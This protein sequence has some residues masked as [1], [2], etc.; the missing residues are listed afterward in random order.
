MKIAI[1]TELYLPSIGGQQVRYAEL[2]K[3]LAARGHSVDVFTIAHQPGLAA[4]ETVDGVRI[5]RLVSAPRYQ[6]KGGFLSRDVGAIARFTLALLARLRTL[7]GYDLVLFNQWPVLPQIVCGRLLGRRAAV[8]WC[9]IRSSRFW[10]VLNRLMALSCARHLCVSEAIGQVLVEKFGRRRDSVAAVLSGIES[11][12][13]AATTAE[14]EDGLILFLGR[15]SE[16]KNPALLVE[17][18]IADPELSSRCHLVLAGDGEQFDTLR[19]RTDGLPSVTL[20][21]L[22]SDAEKIALLRKA[23]LLVLPSRREGFPRVIAEAAAAGTPVVTVDFPDNGSVH[24]V[25]KYGLGWVCAPDAATLG[26]T[27]R[28]RIQRNGAWEE[29]SQRGVDAATRIFDWEAV[30]AAFLLFVG[31]P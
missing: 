12:H 4:E 15:L 28:A 7:R 2:G 11:A 13:Y 17:A 5:V 9:E 25:G 22:V 29:V 18:F 23:A 19:G 20:P 8:D 16:H 31:K 27:M 30:I 24:V 1:V 3:R 6:R 10:T 21:G 14:K 26:A